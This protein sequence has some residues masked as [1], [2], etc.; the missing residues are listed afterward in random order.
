MFQNSKISKFQNPQFNMYFAY[1]A[2][3]FAFFAVKILP[4]GAQR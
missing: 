4:Q 1:F 2:K 3:T